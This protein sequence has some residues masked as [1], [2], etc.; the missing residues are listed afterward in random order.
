METSSLGEKLDFFSPLGF[1]A[2]GKSDHKTSKLN[3]H[4]VKASEQYLR[5][6]ILIHG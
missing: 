3:P 4:P 5:D 2:K 1:E 6:N